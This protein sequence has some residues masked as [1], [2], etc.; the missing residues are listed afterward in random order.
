[1]AVHPWRARRDAARAGQDF[2][3]TPPTPPPPPPPPPPFPPTPFRGPRPELLCTHFVVDCCCADVPGP[4]AGPAYAPQGSRRGFICFVRTHTSCS[5]MA[6][7]TDG[8]QGPTK[9][10]FVSRCELVIQVFSFQDWA[11]AMPRLSFLVKAGDSRILL[12]GNY[13][14]DHAQDLPPTCL[15][16]LVEAEAVV[17][18]LRGGSQFMLRSCPCPAH[19]RELW[20]RPRLLLSCFVVVHN[21]CSGAAPAP[22]MP[23]NFGGGRGCCYPASWWFTIYAQELLQRFPVAFEAEAVVVLARCGLQIMLRSCPGLAHARELWRLRLLLSCFVVH[24]SCTGHGWTVVGST[25]G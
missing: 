22:H 17:I 10:F 23:A 13:F 4:Q 15:R 14:E 11:Q 19:A 7:N 6:M 21:L 8:G 5:G 1:M 12:Q 2:P 24:Q 18:L 25:G 16:T 3:P 20:W 9:G